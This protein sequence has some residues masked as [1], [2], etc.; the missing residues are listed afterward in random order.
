M[1]Y[2]AKLSVIVPIFGV[3][4]FISRCAHSLL[5]QSLRDVEY[6]FVDDASTD[7]SMNI[8]STVIAKFP[9][10]ESQIKIL[11]HERNKGLPAARNTGLSVATGEYIFHCDSDDFVETDMLENLYRVAVL[12]NADVVWCDYYLS[13]ENSER[14]IKQPCYGTS[15]EALKGMLCGR[16]KYNVWNKLVRRK[17]YVDYHIQFP[18]GYAMGEDMTMM[19]LFSYAERVTY[20]PKAFYHYVQWNVGA[21][22][23]EFAPQHLAAL[24]HNT[25]DIL[26]F[27]KS[28]YKDDWN[29]DIYSFCMLMKWPFLIS[30]KKS[31]Y[32]LWKEWFPEA[33][34]YIWRDKQV[35]WRIRF[36]EWCASK[37]WF[38]IVWLHY[39]IVI[40]WLYNII[41][42]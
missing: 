25:G 19:K 23:R 14:Y 40:R 4:C 10:R 37:G 16:M 5:A 29:Q 22:T 32:E 15:V 42:K 27:I 6:I 28:R 17:L 20:I 33:N 21:M 35:S 1:T 26:S 38:G 13:Y 9:Q 34:T 12:H 18:S 7:D 8:L 36:I 30:N 3:E 41:Y 2:M 24:E 31:M 11:A 39:W